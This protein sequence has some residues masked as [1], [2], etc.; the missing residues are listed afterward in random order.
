MTAEAF[1]YA[2][3]PF[4]TVLLRRLTMIGAL[5]AAAGVILFTFGLR[6]AALF[7]GGTFIGELPWPLLRLNEFVLGMCLAWAF[8][9]GWLPR[10][11]FG[12]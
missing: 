8:R 3:H 1:F 6:G 12:A 4:I 11:P 10:V 5:A 2:L 7:D 9:K